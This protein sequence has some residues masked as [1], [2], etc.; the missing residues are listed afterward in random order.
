MTTR[1][2]AV[3]QPGQ[4]ERAKRVARLLATT[5][6]APEFRCR[7][8]LADWLA[9]GASLDVAEQMARDGLAL[10]GSFARLVINPGLMI[11]DMSA[12]GRRLTLDC[13]PWWRAWPARLWY[14]A[15]RLEVADRFTTAAL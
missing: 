3:C 7:R 12:T 10:D 2:R 1:L 14:W 4:L 13:A 6:A 8:S 15:R 11:D 9:A 5:T